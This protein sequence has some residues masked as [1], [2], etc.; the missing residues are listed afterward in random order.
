MLDFPFW[1]NALIWGTCLL[2]A[3][4]ALPVAFYARVEGHND[5]VAFLDAGNPATPEIQT[6]ADSWPGW[7]P[8][9]LV[10]LGLDLRGGAHLL[11]EVQVADTYAERMDNYWPLVRDALRDLKDQVGNVR[12][13]EDDPAVLRVKISEP[14]GMPAALEAVRA[15]AQPVVTLTGV[16]STDIQV[17]NE[18]DEIVIVL[19]EAE[20]IANNDRTM[21]QSLE[22][23]R[24]RVDEAGTREPTI[25][26]Q[27]K[28]RI[29]VQVPGIGSAEELLKLIGKTAKLTFNRVTGRTSDA[30]VVA[31]AGEIIVP[32]LDETG[33]FYVLERRAVV[34][35]DQLVD[36]QPTFDQNGV[37]AVSFRFNPQG[38]RVFGE[39]TAANIGNP[40]AIV[41]DNEV[42][43]APTIQ[44]AIPGGSGQITGSFTV[45]ESTRLAILLR[46]GA[47]PAEITVLEQRV[48]G[49]ELGQDSINA[50]KLASI[51][52]F[53]AVCAYMV[54]SYGIWGM[55]A[56]V[57][58]ILNIVLI[59]AMMSVVGATLTL[60]GIAGIIL[61]IG[62]AVDANVLVFERVREE[63]RSGKGPARALSLGYEKAL[64]AIIDGSLTTL[65]AAVILFALGSGPIRGFA[66]TLGL[67]LITSIF[68]AIWVTRSIIAAWLG[69]RRP[70]TILV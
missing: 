70:K 7:L 5:A 68:T 2:C 50:G 27:G 69:W 65:I 43:S 29:L 33:I 8:N 15:V 14:T 39:Y 20:R 49:P 25:Q 59:F 47:L 40:F 22:I 61:T 3:Y 9:K 32:S 37:P 51:V 56:N 36:A 60:P 6:A 10:N 23:I 57:A 67:G 34:N 66:L 24:R 55:F 30:N 13:I 16:G 11:V 35:G 62:M 19:S 42:I 4:L 46:A 48:I 45:E 31:G 58:L 38:G 64:S 18:A 52:A 41:L 44:T 17:S 63:L 12:R 26:R 21:E 28:D 53:A 1:K 54:L